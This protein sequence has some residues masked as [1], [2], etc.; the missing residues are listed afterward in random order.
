M[1]EHKPATNLAKS[2]ALQGNRRAVKEETEKVKERDVVPLSLKDD[3][4]ERLRQ[5]MIAEQG[6]GY[7]SDEE[8][9]ACFRRLAYAACDA[10]IERM[11]KDAEGAMIL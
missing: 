10:F 3:R 4:R 7:P 1:R 9:R 2:A 11:E 5:A 6:G 8:V